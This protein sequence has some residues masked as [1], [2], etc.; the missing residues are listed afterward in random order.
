M[1]A[2]GF[3]HHLTVKADGADDDCE[4]GYFDVLEDENE[5]YVFD[6]GAG[7]IVNRFAT[8]EQAIACAERRAKQWTERK[9]GES[10]KPAL[11][12]TAGEWEWTGI[13]VEAEG[14]ALAFLL[15]ENKV[16]D[17]RLMAAAP[18]MASALSDMLEI[19]R[20]GSHDAEVCARAA[21][22]LKKAGVL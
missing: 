20:S 15:G 12:W 13:Y 10:P 8:V 22:A 18:E 21:S 3:I 16:A 9:Q 1:I 5:P 7:T 2:D 4:A 11:R 19:A 14:V 6:R 17:G